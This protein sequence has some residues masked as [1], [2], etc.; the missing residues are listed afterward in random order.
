LFNAVPDANRFALLL[1]LLQ[2]S[3]SLV[4]DSAAL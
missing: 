1:E 3:R 2:K 4:G